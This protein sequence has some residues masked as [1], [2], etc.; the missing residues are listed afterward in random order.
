MFALAIRPVNRISNEAAVTVDREDIPCS[1]A[2]CKEHELDGNQ[3]LLID[4]IS[5]VDALS[6][7][8]IDLGSLSI[9]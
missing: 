9:K 2:L 5:T 1:P 3:Y 6:T 8:T 7:I 4:T